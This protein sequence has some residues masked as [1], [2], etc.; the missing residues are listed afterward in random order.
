[1]STTWWNEN[2]IK[3][4]HE[5][6]A[7]NGFKLVRDMRYDYDKISLQVADDNNE[8][9]WTKDMTLEAFN[10]FEQANAFLA[11][12]EKGQMYWNIGKRAKR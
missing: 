3:H 5:L 4:A 11:G 1:M 2:L 12:Y 6:A 8:G 7:K 10:D 9:I